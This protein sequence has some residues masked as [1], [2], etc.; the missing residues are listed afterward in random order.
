MGKSAIKINSLLG[1]TISAITGGDEGSDDLIFHCTDGTT[2]HLYH[3]QEC[4]E[5]VCIEDIC[6]DINDLIDSPILQ[7]EEVD[8]EPPRP[9]P[10]NRSETWTF[11]KFGTIKGYVTV[12]W[13]GCS[14]GYYSEG[15]SLVEIID[16]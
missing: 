15:V 10:E 5:S 6:G 16:D 13:Y 12:R 2:Y 1:K 11:Y 3:V 9:T 7:A 4:C 14:N 8:S